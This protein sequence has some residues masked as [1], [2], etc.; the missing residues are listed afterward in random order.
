[1]QPEKTRSISPLS[2]QEL[3]RA[4]TSSPCLSLREAKG[5]GWVQAGEMMAGLPDLSWKL[6]KIPWTL[7]R[8][9]KA[10]LH[11]LSHLVMLLLQISQ[12][13]FQEIQDFP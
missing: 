6:R 1:M 8:A 5:L 11:R 4:G 13:R 10:Q 7:Y 2:T 12:L 3:T 9:K